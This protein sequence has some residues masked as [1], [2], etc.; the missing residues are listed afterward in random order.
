MRGLVLIGA[1]GLFVLGTTMLSQL[2]GA[3]EALNSPIPGDTQAFALV[4]SLL[5]SAGLFVLISRIGTAVPLNLRY[6]PV[7]NPQDALDRR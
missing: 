5:L 1:L 6:D 7:N 3:L 2:G 4:G